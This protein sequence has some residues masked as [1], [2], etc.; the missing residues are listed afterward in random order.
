MSKAKKNNGCGKFKKWRLATLLLVIYDLLTVAASYYL[1][2]A[3]RFERLSHFP[4][5]FVGWL[6]LTYACFPFTGVVVY[7]L[8]RLYNRLWQFASYRELTDCLGS[9]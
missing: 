2:M 8:W 6:Y 7:W 4:Q 1:A 5:H 3:I 9:F